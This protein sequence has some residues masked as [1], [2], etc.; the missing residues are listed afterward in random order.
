M[1][2]GLL[3]VGG[4]GRAVSHRRPFRKAAPK[5]FREKLR[6]LFVDLQLFEIYRAAVNLSRVELLADKLL[7][8]QELFGNNNL[9]RTRNDGESKL[10]LPQYLPIQLQTSGGCGVDLHRA[11]TVELHARN[12]VYIVIV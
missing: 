8:V 11:G 4:G 6:F 9:Y 12:V 5:A 7:S 2:F 1:V 3:S 10:R